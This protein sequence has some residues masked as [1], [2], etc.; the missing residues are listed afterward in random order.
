MLA[1]EVEAVLNNRSGLL[2]VSGLSDDVRILEQSATP[3]AVE[4]LE[5]FAYRAARELGSLVAALAGLD[6]LV[7]TAGIGEQSAALRRRICELSEWTGIVVDEAANLNND[8]KISA[9]SSS[10]DV[11]VIP[12]NEEIV[13]AHATRKLA[14]G[15]A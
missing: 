9:A 12:T 4:A 15:A 2:G 1:S 3:N 8:P 10:V 5:L 14:L 13:I 7:F 6:I 11:F